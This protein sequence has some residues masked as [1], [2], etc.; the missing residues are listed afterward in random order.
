[1]KFPRTIRLDASDPHVFDHAAEPGEL[2]V[3]GAFAFADLAPDD[4][5]G[6]T[7]QA[8][9]NGFLGLE[10]FGWS[11]LVAVAEVSDDDYQA[12]IRALADHFVDRYGAPDRESA[13]AAAR[14]EAA[15]AAEL[16]D[17]PA[18]TLLTVSRTFGDEGI[19]ERV[20]AVERPGGGDPARVWE[21]VEG[22]HGP[23]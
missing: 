1:M 13:L 10:S 9:A 23:D 22:D 17:H 4:I 21:I 16:C 5:V 20:A 12:A 7:R 2:A 8:F 6:K 11:T 18:N 15:F 14:D 3:P 19:V